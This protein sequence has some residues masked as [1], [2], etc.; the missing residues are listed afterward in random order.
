MT[1]LDPGGGMHEAILPSRAGIETALTG[2]IAAGSVLCSRGLA[3]YAKVADHAGAEHRVIHAPATAPYAG[4]TD[5]LPARPR[6]AGRL[7]LGRVNAHHRRL[8]TFINRRCRGVATRYLANNLG[9]N[10]AMLCGVAGTAL[11]DQALA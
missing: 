4:E 9:W 5:A 8:K 11:L 10:R 1:A 6:R 2:R 3:A 7:G